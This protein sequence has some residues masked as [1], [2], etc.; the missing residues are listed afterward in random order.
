MGDINE[1]IL[2][3]NIRR[4]MV[5]LGLTET[6]TKKHGGQGTE[7]TREKNKGQAIDG[8]WASQGIIISQGVYPP[9][10]YDHKSDHMLLWIKISHETAFG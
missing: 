7:T 9:F 2:S 3:H 8:I 4:F 5:N 1:Y 10:H 6:I